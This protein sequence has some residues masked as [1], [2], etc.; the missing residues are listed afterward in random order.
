MNLIRTGRLLQSLRK[1]KGL[2]QEEVAEKVGVARR[3]VSRWETGN[4]MPDLDI[5]IELSD[6]YE[7]DLQE[8]L[9]GER[10]GEQMNDELKETVLAVADYSNE[11]K[12]KMLRGMHRV[13]IAGL[14]GLIGFMVLWICDVDGTMPYVYISGFCLGVPLAAVIFGAIYTS[15]HFARIR[16]CKQRL[17]GKHK[18]GSKDR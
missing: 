16:R 3:T 8:I 18:K 2:T 5:L 1:E 6:L 17:L 15:K 4:N 13:S 12:A 7:V 14:L 9:R 10:K 11:E